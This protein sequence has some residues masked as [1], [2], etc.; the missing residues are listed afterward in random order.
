[1]GGIKLT[2]NQLKFK[3]TMPSRIKP[4]T[5]KISPALYKPAEAEFK[6][7]LGYFYEPCD[8]MWAS[9]LVVASKTTTPFIRFCVN[10]RKVNQYIEYG[11]QP[12]P[13]VSATLQ[14]LL[15]YKYF[16][17]I[18]LK[19]AF[20]QILLDTDTSQRLS[21]QTLWGQYRPKF[22]PEVVNAATGV[23][24]IAMQ[25][26]F[27]HLG[28]WCYLLFDNVLLG[29]TSYQDCYSKIHQFL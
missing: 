23:L 3:E 9:P 22:L 29:G 19:S 18:D 2:T 13:N 1:M 16:M 12:I 24:Q 5:V 21:V 11:H 17:N 25:N 20:H 26:I 6:R 14:S 15:P 8:S 28:D 27:G 7:M 4:Y 10:M